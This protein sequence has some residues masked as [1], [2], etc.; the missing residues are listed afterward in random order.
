MT[1]RELEQD[2]WSAGSEDEEGSIELPP[3]LTDPQGVVR[4][5]WLWMA[6]SLMAGL[7]ATGAVVAS[8]KPSFKAEA[9]LLITS[10]QIPE[11]FVRSTV[12][13]SISNINAMVGQVLSQENLSRLIDELQLD[14]GARDKESR[15]DLIKRMRDKIVVEPTEDF[16]DTRHAASLIYGVSYEAEKPEQAAAVANALAGLFIEASIERRNQQA[17]TTTE[18]LRRALERNELELREHSG[19]VSAFRRAHRG[20]LPDELNTNL[21]KLDLAEQR[22]RGLLDQIASKRNA[23]ATLSAEPPA[24]EASENEILLQELRRDL[25]REVAVH[26]EE[27]PNV[28]ALR[29]R[30]ARLDEVVRAERA[31]DTG[32]TPQVERVLATERFDLGRMQDQLAETESE[33]A[34]LKE[35]IDRT[36]AISEELTALEEKESVLRDDYLSALRK[37]EDAELAESLELAQ[38]GAQVSILD[39]AQPPGSPK[40][41]LWMVFAGS[42]A[43]TLGLAL[44]VG[45][46]LE[47]VDPVVVSARQLESIAERPALGALP[48]IA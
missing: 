26:T 24:H 25:A 6:L 32:P 27:H 41:P 22:R 36:P 14:A 17:R 18:F 9:T 16:S 35:R 1:Q 28:A 38:Q 39:P 7:V 48:K 29:R 45:V 10:Q 13:D 31:A 44:A 5:R 20:E 4:R 15:L 47:L 21:R 8:W 3:F 33:L 42:L 43:G 30:V 19:T 37:V 23:I 40:R 11:D 34:Q 12:Q 46:G 2:V